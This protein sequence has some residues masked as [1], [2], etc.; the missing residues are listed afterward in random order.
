[1]VCLIFIPFILGGLLLSQA[2]EMSKAEIS[3]VVPDMP[4]EL[5][6]GD[7]YI[8]MRLLQI[9]ATR[10]RRTLHMPALASSNLDTGVDCEAFVQA[11][12]IFRYLQG[13]SDNPVMDQ[14]FLDDKL[15]HGYFKFDSQNG[16]EATRQAVAIGAL[17]GLARLAQ[18]NKKD[19]KASTYESLVKVANKLPLTLYN[20]LRL[21]KSSRN[22]VIKRVVNDGIIAAYWYHSQS[23]IPTLPQTFRALRQQLGMPIPSK[24]T[25]DESTDPGVI[26]QQLLTLY[27]YED[28]LELESSVPTRHNLGLLFK[29]LQKKTTITMPDLY[30]GMS[31][32][33]ESF[34]AV[35]SALF[36]KQ[37]REMPHNVLIGELFV[38]QG[39]L[40]WAE[41]RTGFASK[42]Q[43][44]FETTTKGDI[45]IAW[46]TIEQS[47]K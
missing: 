9:P 3:S 47:F 5:L 34:N 12:N 1:M 25:N 18:G 44:V 19:V 30:S 10:I 33:A 13:Q 39:C 7:E 37:P 40:M 16:V 23:T 36:G 45:M 6:E 4:R 8:D 41:E 46:T 35:L 42:I 15:L 32:R 20:M 17:K 43:K 2:A 29:E 28:R 11:L 38:L 26:I 22:A 21:G 14:D 31:T 27:Y 24:N